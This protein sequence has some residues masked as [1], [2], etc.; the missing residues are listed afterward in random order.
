MEIINKKE[1]QITF[2]ADIDTS[3]ANAIRR[4]VNQIPILAIDE[5]EIVKN[6]GALYD[7]VVAHRLGLVPLKMDKA[8]GNKGKLKLVTKKEGMVKSK[9]LKGN[10]D[11]VFEDIPIT[12]LDKDQE[13]ELIATTKEGIG[14]EHV[15]FSPGLMFYRNISEITMD[16]DFLEDVK[17]I[18]PNANIKEKGNKII[19]I[20]DQPKGILDICEGITDKI[21][22][23]TEVETKKELIISL[24]SFGQMDVKD[25]FT[26]SVDILKKDLA[27]V[28][29]KIK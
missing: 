26:K 15:K 29:K 20:D 24:E 9:E 12:F 7:E 17:K 21:G 16:K 14:N 19:I 1:N 23:D 2:K 22:K 4:Y 18:C 8:I 13:I 3:L 27:E 6:G 10:V 25:I 28:S 11:V 5:V